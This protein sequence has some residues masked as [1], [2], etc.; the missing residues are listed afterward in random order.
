[1]QELS[2]EPISHTPPNRENP[3]TIDKLLSPRAVSASPPTS[4]GD[5]S[6]GTTGTQAQGDIPDRAPTDEER[7]ALRAQRNR[8]SAQRSRD[9]ARLM[10][11]ALRQKVGVLESERGR[12]TQLLEQKETELSDAR[13]LIQYLAGCMLHQ[14]GAGQ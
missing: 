2:L 8:D 3:V 4:I 14:Q 6:G 1:L 11:E 7:R 5:H 9:R 12:L 10:T 13:A